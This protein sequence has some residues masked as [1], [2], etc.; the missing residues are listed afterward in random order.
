MNR[1]MSNSLNV[2]PQK[3][4]DLP[5]TKVL[6]EGSLNVENKDYNYIYLFETLEE[7]QEI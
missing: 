3:N 6:R 1:C 5:S 2:V 7:A 4:M